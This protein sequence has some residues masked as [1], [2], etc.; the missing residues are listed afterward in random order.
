MITVHAATPRHPVRCKPQRIGDICALL[1]PGLEQAVDSRRRARNSD[2]LISLPLPQ[3]V[4]LFPDHAANRGENERG[5]VF[6]EIPHRCPE[7]AV[8]Q[9]TPQQILLVE[10][11][12]PLPV[13]GVEGHPYL[14]PQIF[15]ARGGGRL[16]GIHFP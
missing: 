13:S 15:R 3:F 7:P 11:A 8:G 14:Q 1:F 5:E 9:D 2:S 4:N 10:F 16:N 6:F 12:N